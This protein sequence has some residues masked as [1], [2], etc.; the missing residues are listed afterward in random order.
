MVALVATEAQRLERE[1]RE[2]NRLGVARTE[3]KR[4]KTFPIQVLGEVAPA[5]AGAMKVPMY[6]LGV[7]PGRR[8]VA[9]MPLDPCLS[10]LRFPA[11][12]EIARG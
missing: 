4:N 6:Q 2:A 8:P 1:A 5:G 9:G 12:S 3:A 10:L 11:A 7:A